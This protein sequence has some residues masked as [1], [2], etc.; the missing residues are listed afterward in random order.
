MLINLSWVQ[1]TGFSEALR[2]TGGFVFMIQGK[3]LTESS[4]SLLYYPVSDI[5]ISYTCR[6]DTKEKVSAVTQV[7]LLR[8]KSS[9]MESRMI[10]LC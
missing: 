6:K 3:M 2:Q 9:L 1:E 7:R 4:V 5:R 8:L 10:K